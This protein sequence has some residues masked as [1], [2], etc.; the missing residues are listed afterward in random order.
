MARDAAGPDPAGLVNPNHPRAGEIPHHLD[1]VLAEDEPPAQQQ[2]LAD[3]TL[4][5]PDR[6]ALGR[7]VHLAEQRSARAGGQ[8]P[9]FL[10]RRR[11]ARLGHGQPRPEPAHRP[12]EPQ[13]PPQRSAQRHHGRAL[14]ERLP[15]RELLP[16]PPGVPDGQHRRRRRRRIADGYGPHADPR[17]RVAAQRDARAE[18]RRELQLPA[19]AGDPERERAF[20]DAHVLRRSVG[21]PQQQQRALSA[22]LPDA[23]DRAAVAAGQRRRRQRRRV[24]G[25]EPQGRESVLDVVPGRLADDVAPDAEP[26]RALRHRLELP[27][28]GE[29]PEQRDEAGAARRLGIRTAACRRRSTR[30]SRRESDSPTTWRGMGGGCCAAAT[31]STSIRSTISRWATSRRRATAR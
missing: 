9:A 24:L 2:S 23:R 28:R 14:L 15:Q 20:R 8:L 6:H 5:G 21:D 16:A 25:R 12:H 29:Q 1:D 30:T 19:P 11:P 13:R 22:G 10:E 26:G 18:V 3:G 17:R 27:R 7:D 4:R 31:G